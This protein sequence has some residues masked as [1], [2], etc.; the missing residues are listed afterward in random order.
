ME[1]RVGRA[2]SVDGGVAV[3]AGGLGEAA[4]AGIVGCRK[5]SGLWAGDWRDGEEVFPSAAL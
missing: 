2:R 3:A 1:L 5:A 4:A